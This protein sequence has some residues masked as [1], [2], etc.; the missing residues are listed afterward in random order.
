MNE[1][2]APF[3]LGYDG[4]LLTLLYFAGAC[5][6]L[7]PVFDCLGVNRYGPLRLPQARAVAC[8]AFL[9][10]LIAGRIE[11]SPIDEAGVEFLKDHFNATPYIDVEKPLREVVT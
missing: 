9:L 7:E 4:R 1:L 2:I 10:D 8:L 3:H 6:V 11:E 5:T